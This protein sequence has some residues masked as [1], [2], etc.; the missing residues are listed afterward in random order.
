MSPVA[1]S[2]TGKAHTFADCRRPRHHTYGAEALLRCCAIRVPHA[3]PRVNYR[4][5]ATMCSV[6]IV[7]NMLARFDAHAYAGRVCCR[8]CA[9]GMFAGGSH[10]V[11][12]SLRCECVCVTTPH[13]SGRENN[14]IMWNSG[15]RTESQN[16][17]SRDT[18]THVRT[19]GR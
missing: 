4:N 16:A 5:C 12:E 7:N 15:H 9:G 8:N 14:R 1:F 19:Q 18:H 3:R 13:G 6:R 10:T 11:R 17:C 2:F